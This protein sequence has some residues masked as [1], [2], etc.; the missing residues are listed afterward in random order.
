[1]LSYIVELSIYFL[2]VLIAALMRAAA[3]ANVRIYSMFS[4]DSKLFPC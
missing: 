1:M 2:L 4:F 3:K